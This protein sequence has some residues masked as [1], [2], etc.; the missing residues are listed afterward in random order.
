MMVPP[1]PT[2]VRITVLPT[3]ETSKL[4]RHVVAS[5]RTNTS[6]PLLDGVHNAVQCSLDGLDRRPSPEWQLL[7]ELA[8]SEI[9]ANIAEHAQ[10][11]AIRL[12]ITAVADR[13]MAE[14]TD[15]GRPWYGSPGPGALSDHLAESGR[16]LSLVRTAVDQ[17][18]YERTD[19][20]NHWRLMK[21]RS[22][23]MRSVITNVLSKLKESPEYWA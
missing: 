5:F 6:Q 10:P 16:G 3:P 11:S 14:F 12:R 20:T 1:R 8:V 19:R 15:D 9:A 18:H 21:T 13:V 7:F 23:R 4:E 2:Q 22:S 17:L